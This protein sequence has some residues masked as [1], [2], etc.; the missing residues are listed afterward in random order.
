VLHVKNKNNYFLIHSR[1]QI[2]LWVTTEGKLRFYL[3]SYLDQ[4]NRPG[5]KV[6]M[7]AV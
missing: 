4:R 6:C 5:N 2:P 1:Q 3:V 7:G